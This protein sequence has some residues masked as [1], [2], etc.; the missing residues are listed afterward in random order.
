MIEYLNR[1]NQPIDLSRHQFHY[2]LGGLRGGLM[3][4]TVSEP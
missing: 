3:I 4:L 1:R 2:R